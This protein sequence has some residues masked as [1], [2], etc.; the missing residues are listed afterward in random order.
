LTASVA[1]LHRELAAAL[2]K[3]GLYA[4]E[5]AAMIDTWRD[6]WFEE[7]MRVFYILPR[8]IVDETL[9]IKI[10]PAPAATVRVFVGRVEILSPAMKESL[11]S[12]LATGD[13]ATLEKCGRFLETFQPRIRHAVVSP[14]AQAFID[15]MRAQNT[16][17][18]SPCK[19][20]LSLPTNQ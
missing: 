9:P 17:R 18:V 20:P 5:A 11:A 12:A 1:S 13:T 7:G 6:S 4:K 14:A 8:A 16:N 19:E 3:A 15:G 10:T 2:T